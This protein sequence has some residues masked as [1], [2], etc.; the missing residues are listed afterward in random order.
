MPTAIYLDKEISEYEITTCPS[1]EKNTTKHITIS[2]I[3]LGGYGI[4][5]N[6]D[7]SIWPLTMRLL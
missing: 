5:C 4:E 7:I 1:P 2:I 3:L 6:W